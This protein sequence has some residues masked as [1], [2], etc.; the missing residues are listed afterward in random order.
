MPFPASFSGGPLDGEILQ[1]TGAGQT[2]QA[3]LQVGGST[4]RTYTYNRILAQNEA[5]TPLSGP[6]LYQHQ[7][8]KKT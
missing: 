6:H 2:V 5:A 4:I 8:N 7:A 1:L 3:V